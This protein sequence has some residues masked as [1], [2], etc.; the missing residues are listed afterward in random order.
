M[1]LRSHEPESLGAASDGGS[2]DTGD[3]PEDPLLAETVLFKTAIGL[4]RSIWGSAKNV[5]GAICPKCVPR[6]FL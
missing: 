5:F 2:T 3:L 6:A 4:K 1:N